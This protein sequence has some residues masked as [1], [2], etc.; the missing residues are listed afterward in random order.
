MQK[1]NLLYCGDNL[2]ILREYLPDESVDLIYLDP[3][4]SSKR[5]YN[6]VFRKKGMAD[7]RIRAFDDIWRWD[8]STAVAYQ[9]LL[10]AANN[11]SQTMQAFH[12]LLST[13]N[14]LAYLTM[15]ASRLVELRRVLKPL[16]LIHI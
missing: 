2:S 6:I 1:H 3:P 7:L 5:L 14:M 12:M 9:D 16:S 10:K 13:N 4:F 8:N 15:M 11:I